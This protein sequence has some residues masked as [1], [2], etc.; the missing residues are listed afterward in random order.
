MPDSVITN[1][2]LCPHAT[3]RALSM[4]SS[5]GTSMVAG[6]RMSAIEALAFPAPI[7]FLEEVS[8]SAVTELMI[9]L[10]RACVEP[11]QYT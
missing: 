2:K 8:V 1:V 7:S 3:I 9:G 11:Q 4:P 6:M 10:H 5:S